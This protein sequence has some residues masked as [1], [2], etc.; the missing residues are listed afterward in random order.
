MCVI[1]ILLTAFASQFT[2]FFDLRFTF[3]KSRVNESGSWCS[4]CEQSVEP[5]VHMIGMDPYFATY[6]SFRILFVYLVPC[7]ALITL[8]C[9]LYH[10]LKR[11]ERRRHALLKCPSNQLDEISKSWT[12]RQT[13]TNERKSE[14]LCSNKATTT[15]TT[16]KTL[17]T[18]SST[19]AIAR[20]R[21]TSNHDIG[22]HENDAGE[23]AHKIDTAS[24]YH[25]P[26][27][28]RRKI[29]LVTI[30]GLERDISDRDNLANDEIEETCFCSF[31][32]ECNS[33]GNECSRCDMDETTLPTIA[34]TTKIA[35]SN[36]NT[37][38]A[39]RPS[40]S[41]ETPINSR[42]GKDKITMSSIVSC[43][44]RVSL[45][46]PDS[47]ENSTTP[48]LKA[49]NSGITTN[50]GHEQVRFLIKE[51]TQKEQVAKGTNDKTTI[52]DGCSVR[53]V[54]E[55]S[56]RFCVSSS[57]FGGASSSQRSGCELETDEDGTKLDD[58]EDEDGDEDE[59][60]Y[61][62]GA[63][64]SR[65]MASS[66]KE[67]ITRSSASLN[68][69]VQPVL[70]APVS[71]QVAASNSQADSSQG[72]P[73][74][75]GARRSRLGSINLLK[76]FSRR[77]DSN[78]TTLMLIV[79]VT[80]FLAVEVPSAIVTTLHFT[81]TAF[82]VLKDNEYLMT[83]ISYTKLYSNFLIMVSYS[84]NFSIYCSMSYMFRQTFRN[85][86]TFGRAARDEIRTFHSHSHSHG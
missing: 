80:V 72:L 24:W 63:Q 79:V 58:D 9:L 56:M 75:S 51:E 33:E 34:T 62:L 17:P 30:N 55:P 26:T 48:I 37:K 85:L 86:L 65:L 71:S 39:S 41:S 15:S 49:S 21:E 28:D 69:F 61:E 5:W 25:H 23:I 35:T 20:T 53:P 27:L 12:V 78:R 70:M 1:I 14:L 84:L 42:M 57:S 40:S 4:V 66:Q 10:A 74:I 77:R 68:N 7:T 13:T 31:D 6:F 2:R 29:V 19:L 83:F 60:D 44:S 3:V 52:F 81:T 67:S 54:V 64:S 22:D 45:D 36:S 43:H 50:Q 11:A 18:T 76:R 82:G 47:S 32:C 38:V 59:E 73:V 46:N 16:T 8:N